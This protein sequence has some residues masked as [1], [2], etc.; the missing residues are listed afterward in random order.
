MGARAQASAEADALPGPEAWLA[1]I[2]ALES[3]GRLDEAA[4]ERERLEEAYPGWL[5]Q[6]APARD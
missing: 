4:I 2:E 5:A 6:H 3:A 1:R